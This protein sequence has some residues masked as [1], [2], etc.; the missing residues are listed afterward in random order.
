ML[1]PAF[2]ASASDFVSGNNGSEIMPIVIWY[3]R[4][5]DIELMQQVFLN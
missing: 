2:E 5:Q 4:I 1:M 3:Y